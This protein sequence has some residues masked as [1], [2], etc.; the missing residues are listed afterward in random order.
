[1]ASKQ[2]R[3]PE[4]TDNGIE[5]DDTEESGTEQINGKEARKN[6]AVADLNDKVSELNKTREELQAELLRAKREIKYLKRAAAED[7]KL[8]AA[9][10]EQKDRELNKARLEHRE[11]IDLRNV[12]EK[13]SGKG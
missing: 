2:A 13:S 10:V 6:A 3:L 7:R 1:M 5:S 9:E 12:K 11:L 4:E 8:Y